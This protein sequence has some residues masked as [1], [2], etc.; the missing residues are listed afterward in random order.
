M[1]KK[2]T[3]TAIV[4]LL[5]LLSA[6]AGAQYV[7]IEVEDN[8]TTILSVKAEWHPWKQEA[9]FGVRPV[10]Q[11]FEIQHLRAS[12]EDSTM[13]AAGQIMAVDGS[14]VSGPQEISSRINVNYTHLAYNGTVKFSESET[15][16]DLDGFFGLGRVNFVLRSSGST[17]GP[18]A[19]R[20]D[21]IDH[22]LSLGLGLR[23]WIH[24]R[25]AL[26]GRLLLFSQ[27]PFSFFGSF[28]HGTQTDL[29]E[30]ELVWVFAPIRNVA[31][32]AGYAMT[33]CTPEESGGSSL[34]AN[35]SGPFLGMG[36]LF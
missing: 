3:Q 25:N 1:R 29:W 17:S 7:P 28:G 8:N 16:L 10:E 15:P 32:R 34:K 19:L 23:W 14:T 26:E 20:A 6:C 2:V 9:G 30:V 5:L 13:L 36:F 22:G 4:G 27:N 12:G 11:G 31:V 33:Q 21:M 18:D 24:A 35:F